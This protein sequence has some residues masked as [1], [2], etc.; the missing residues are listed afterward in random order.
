MRKW[1]IIDKKVIFSIVGETVMNE[2]DLHLSDLVLLKEIAEM[3]N[4]GTDLPL[5]LQGVL[6]QLL[7]VLHLETGWIF[8]LNEQQ[9]LQLAASVNLP[10]GLQNE[11]F[12][13]MCAQECYCMDRF[14]DGRLKKAV[15]VMACKRLQD[16]VAN[17]YGDTRGLAHHASV[18]LRSG[19]EFVGILNVALSSK[20]LFKEE[21]LPLLESVA[22][23]IGSTVKRIR[24]TEENRQIAIG[25]ERQRLA[26]EL[27]DSVKQLLFST[28]LLAKTGVSISLD[29][30]TRQLFMDISNVAQTAQSEMKEL[31]WQLRPQVL[32]KG[33]IQAIKDYA[34]MLGMTVETDIRADI[35]LEE[36]T[37][38]EIWRI[39]QEA[40]N[41]SKKHS[42]TSMIHL[43]SYRDDEML[44]LKIRDNG[45]GFDFNPNAQL[46]SFGLRNIINR[47]RKIDGT[48]NILSAIGKGTEITITFPI[49]GGA[50][51]NFAI[52][53][54]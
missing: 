49:S 43:T 50:Y 7:K 33:L 26:Q 29:Q 2:K 15:N 52:D 47:A 13:P 42:G 35:M 3:L 12:M 45:S 23:Q 51:G 17:H 46:P 10:P 41:N 6:N 1:Y 27:H 53:S 19:S 31:I 4:Q 20:E 44:I 21:E 16:A 32:E 25:E 14:H 8:L 48:V 34:K 9:E 5:V 22:L 54:R 28:N 38:E 40:I 18:A 37:E 24:L 36:E 11:E 30:A 39:A